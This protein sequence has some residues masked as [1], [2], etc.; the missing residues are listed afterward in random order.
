M[1]VR[2]EK[3]RNP[4]SDEV[5]ALTAVVRPMEFFMGLRPMSPVKR[6]VTTTSNSRCCRAFDAQVM[7][8]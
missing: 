4:V 3:Q 6:A 5:L 2:R 7:A 8:I 1:R